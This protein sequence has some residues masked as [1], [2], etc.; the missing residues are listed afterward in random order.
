MIGTE[1]LAS[2]AP[3]WVL[4]SSCDPQS[5]QGEIRHDFPSFVYVAVRGEA[6]Q[7]KAALFKEFA[8]ALHFPDYFG[9][10]WD[11]FDECINDLEWLDGSGYV[12]AVRHA[13]RVLANDDADY[14]KLID[15]LS[16]AGNEWAAPPDQRAPR[17]FHVVFVVSS[18]EDVRRRDWGLAQASFGRVSR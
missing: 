15:I 10:N 12:I 8:H 13:E 11:A 6:C 4:L 2:L 16:K 5:L 9:H 17:P 7:T 18:P 3:P 1:H 14:A